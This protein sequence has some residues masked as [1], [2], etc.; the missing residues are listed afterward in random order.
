MS[1][2]VTIEHRLP[3]F[4]IDVDCEFAG[5]G[6]SALFGPSGA[7]KSTIINAIAGLLRPDRGRIAIDGVCLTDTSAGVFVPPRQRRIG[8]VFQE[9]RLFPHLSVEKNLRFGWRR[10]PERASED[11]I[12]ALIDLLGI[13]DIRTRRPHALSG[14]EKQRV[15]LA[16]ALLSNPR[17]LLLDEPLAALDHKRRDEILPYLERIRSEQQLPIIYVSHSID[18][19]TRLADT[20][21]IVDAG[22]IVASGSIEDVFSR[23]DL[24][25]VTG[26]FEAGTVIDGVI[27]QH[28]DGFHLTRIRCGDEQMV[29]PKIDGREGDKVRIRVRARDIIVSRERPADISANNVIAGTVSAIRHDDGA[30][31]DVQIQCGNSMRLIARITRQSAERLALADNIPVYAVIKS[32]TIDRRSLR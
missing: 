19:V 22:R 12:S 25:P 2:S 31:S 14:G 10:A 1:I 3:E 9:P 23:I 24:Y 6:I 11:E 29:V 17:L 26:R 16:R 7:G 15:A 18:E 32:V 30:F 28:D 21:H 27:D 8:Y 13:A 20:V 5:D 4:A